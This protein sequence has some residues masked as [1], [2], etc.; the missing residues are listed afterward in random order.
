MSLLSG[1]S[2]VYSFENQI[3]TRLRASVL[4]F[5]GEYT[6]E[7]QYRFIELQTPY[8]GAGRLDGNRPHELIGS[9][10]VRRSLRG[11]GNPNTL[12]GL[13]IKNGFHQKFRAGVPAGTASA[14]RSPNPQAKCAGLAHCGKLETRER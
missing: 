3:L 6:R 5:F 4:S 13:P 12:L 7:G 11:A 10:Q 14:G 1:D 2:L 8:N 9:F